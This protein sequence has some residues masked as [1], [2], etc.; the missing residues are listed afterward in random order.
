MHVPQVYQE[1]LEL[2][3]YGPQSH[4]PSAQS[5][6]SRAS[7]AATQRGPQTDRDRKGC[8]SKLRDLVGRCA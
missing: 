7:S 8:V 2:K 4:H 5:A 3:Y 6:R 1:Q